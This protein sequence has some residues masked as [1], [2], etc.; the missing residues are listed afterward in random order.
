MA[1]RV[2]VVRVTLTGLLGVSVTPA[3][4]VHT[5]FKVTGTSTDG[6][7]STVTVQIRVTVD[8]M[9]IIPVG[10]LVMLMVGVGTKQRVMLNFRS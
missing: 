4:P 6:L 2:Y 8:P 7:N 10:L 3:G 1:V 5:V 9:V